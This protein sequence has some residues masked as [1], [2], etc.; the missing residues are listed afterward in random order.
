MKYHFRVSPQ[1]SLDWMEEQEGG[2]KNRNSVYTYTPYRKKKKKRVFGASPHCRPRDVEPEYAVDRGITYPASS[3][4]PVRRRS[5]HR[6]GIDPSSSSRHRL[7][8]KVVD[9]AANRLFWAPSPRLQTPKV[10]LWGKQAIAQLLSGS[11]ERA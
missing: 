3:P 4:S 7:G 6:S 1:Q 8:A 10:Q 11:I 2:E 5:G 9:W